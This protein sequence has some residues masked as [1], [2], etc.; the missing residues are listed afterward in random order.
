[1]QEVD[2]R[3]EPQGR[4]ASRAVDECVARGAENLE[5]LP[6]LTDPLGVVRLRAEDRTEEIVVVRGAVEA[7]L[8]K[9]GVHVS[10]P[11]ALHAECND[12][13]ADAQ[14]LPG[15]PGEQECL[16]GPSTAL[17]QQRHGGVTG[18]SDEVRLHG[19][20][21]EGRAP[22]GAPVVRDLIQAVPGPGA[23]F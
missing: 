20:T 14:A 6:A 3:F 18:G 19:L 7:L 9:G 23:G 4:S 12:Q 21:L 11:P 5:L 22:L 13:K 8:R 1:M 2:A 17:S 16:G 15:D 10:D